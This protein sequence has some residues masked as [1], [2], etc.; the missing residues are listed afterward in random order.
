MRWTMPRISNPCL[1]LRP[2]LRLQRKHPAGPGH[3]MIHIPLIP[4]I[5]SSCISPKL[6]LRSF[7]VHLGLASKRHRSV[8]RFTLVG[9]VLALWV[10]TSAIAASPQLHQLLH[11][12]AQHLNHYCLYTQ[13]SQH[14]F[15]ADFTPTLAPEPPASTTRAPSLS[16]SE[17]L[18]S[19]DYVVSHGRA[20]PAL[21]SSTAVAG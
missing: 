2:G 5:I 8:A 10:A 15:L 1:P 6:W 14:S 13:L 4:I 12:D 21:S 17:S 7:T 3:H 20:P 18:P 16:S 11:Q 19:F 9:L